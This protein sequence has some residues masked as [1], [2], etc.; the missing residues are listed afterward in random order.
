MKNFVQV[1]SR[2]FEK[3]CNEKF[4]IKSQICEIVTV[5]FKNF[6]IVLYY[7]GD[8]YNLRLE[9]YRNKPF[10]KRKLVELKMVLRSVGCG[11]DKIPEYKFIST[12]EEG[13]IN[14]LV[15]CIALINEYFKELS[16]LDLKTVR[17]LHRESKQSIE[18]KV[19]KKY[20]NMPV[21]ARQ[22]KKISI[23]GRVAY[24]ICCL[25][26]ALENY[27]IQGEG[28]NFLLKKLWWYMELRAECDPKINNCYPLELWADLIATIQPDILKTFATY[29]DF[30]EGHWYF[31]RIIPTE[32]EYNL[33]K[34]TVKD[35]NRVIDEICKPLHKMGSCELWCGIKGYSP[36]T[37]DYLQRLLNVMYENNI[38]LPSKEPFEQYVFCKKGWDWDSEFYAFGEM[39]DGTQYSKFIK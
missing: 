33:L 27:N 37:L 35:S 16:N 20:A 26:N 38:P 4:A 11:E 32:E 2:S 13:R 7:F 14:Y 12:D 39:F 8:E 15:K 9:Y 21:N 24:G 36:D 10:C 1:V 34:S 3:Y 25:E 30:T 31:E 29:K 6:G 22:F 18:Q 23:R 17:V 5:S 19:S 28:W